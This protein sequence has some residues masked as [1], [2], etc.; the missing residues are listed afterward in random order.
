MVLQAKTSEIFEALNLA[1]GA[2]L[3]NELTVN[4]WGIELTIH[5]LYDPE[6]A[7]T[8]FQITF[9]DCRKTVWDAFDVEDAIAENNALQADVIGMD[10][11]EAQHRKPAV[12]TTDLFEIAITYGELV[13][14]KDW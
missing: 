13:I 2:W 8:Q 10:I 5:A 9:K 6:E 7:D 12:I 1:R 3:I 14:Q 4:Q 11:G